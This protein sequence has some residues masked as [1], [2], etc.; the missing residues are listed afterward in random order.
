[1][2]GYQ[3]NSNTAPIPGNLLPPARLPLQSTDLV[4][5]VQNGVARQIAAGTFYSAF[6]P[7]LANP[8]DQEVAFTIGQ[9]LVIPGPLTANIDIVVKPTAL[10]FPLLITIPA[11]TGSLWSVNVYADVATLSA[12]TNIITVQP[13]SGSIAGASQGTATIYTPYGSLS[14]KDTATA[15]WMP[16]P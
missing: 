2:S 1:M 10:V 14:V 16:A 12:P 13:A 9:T 15:G 3:G 5:V 11:A 6:G 8:N 4:I 7:F